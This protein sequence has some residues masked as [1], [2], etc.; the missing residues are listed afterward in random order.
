MATTPTGLD[1]DIF[2]WSLPAGA[3]GG[4]NGLLN[5][6][7]LLQTPTQ[8][9]PLIEAVSASS[10]RMKAP[11][12][13]AP[14]P[15]DNISRV[16]VGLA[17]PGTFTLEFAVQL[18]A[19]PR[20]DS[21]P[22]RYIFIGAA[23]AQGGTGGLLL[24]DAGI[25]VVG[26]PDGASIFLPGSEGLL[27]D[28]DDVLLAEDLTFRLVVQ[29]EKDQ[30]DLYVT[31]ASLL[32]SGHVLRYTLPVPATTLG[33][34]DTALVELRG[35]VGFLED[36]TPED[37]P[38]LQLKS[39][40]LSSKALIPNKRPI[41]SV[42]ADQTVNKAQLVQ[43]SGTGSSDAE[44]VALT[45]AWTI[46]AQPEGSNIKL[47]GAQPAYDEFG[48]AA[49]LYY[50]GQA[51]PGFAVGA[52]IHNGPAGQSEL[53]TASAVVDSSDPVG[54]F[55]YVLSSTA[56]FTVGDVITDDTN[57]VT[58][59]SISY[60]N[61]IKI[62]SKLSGSGGNGQIVKVEKPTI[63]DDASELMMSVE[64]DGSVLITLRFQNGTPVGTTTPQELY[65]AL[66]VSSA[67][68]YN[69]QVALLLSAE[70][71]AGGFGSEGMVGADLVLA[72]GVDS[73]EATPSFYATHVGQY[74]FQLVVSD[75]VL[76][77][78]P[79]TMF[80][81]CLETTTALGYVP[82]ADFVWSY[83][84]DFWAK[85]TDKGKVTSFW[86]GLIQLVGAEMLRL[87]GI[88]YN[89]S[90]RDIPALMPHR[91]YGFS[92]RVLPTTFVV[93]DEDKKDK[94]TF[95]LIKNADGSENTAMHCRPVD[96]PD[97]DLLTQTLVFD[98]A[99]QHEKPGSP[100]PGDFVTVVTG[101]GSLFAQ[102]Q[103]FEKF[104]GEGTK[105]VLVD[106]GNTLTD[107]TVDFHAL[108]VVAGTTITLSGGPAQ[109]NQ[110]TVKSVAKTVLTFTA[111]T[112]LGGAPLVDHGW[113]AG[114][115]IVIEEDVIPSYQVIASGVKSGQSKGS[116]V[117]GNT[118][119]FDLSHGEFDGDVQAG[120][121]LVLD[122]LEWGDTKN[123]VAVKVPAFHE[124]ELETDISAGWKGI[125]W[126]VVRSLAEEAVSVEFSPYL[127]VQEDL[128]G[129]LSPGDL[130]SFGAAGAPPLTGM[131]LSVGE[132]GI[133]IRCPSLTSSYELLE[134]IRVVGVTGPEE[135][136]A[137]PR[138]QTSGSQQ[139]TVLSSPLDYTLADY[140]TRSDEPLRQITFVH[141]KKTD[142]AH[143]VGT[144][145]SSATSDFTG[146]EGQYLFFHFKGE[147]AYG[148]HKIT[149]VLSP[150]SVELETN[151]PEPSTGIE[152]SVLPYHAHKLPPLN[153]WA[154][155]VYVD[156]SETIEN[157]FGL[158]VGL[159][160]DDLEE[161]GVEYLPAVKAVW[162]ALWHG[163]TVSNIRLGVQA[164]FNLP[165]AEE[166]GLII[167]ID[168]DY[169]EDT[170][171]VLVQDT[172]NAQSVRSYYY[173]LG[174]GLAHN[175][176]AH[177]ILGARLLK[178]SQEMDVLQELSI[179]EAEDLARDLLSG[180][181]I[182]NEALIRSHDPN[183]TDRMTAPGYFPYL[184]G[185]EVEAFAPL[186]RGAKVVDYVSDPDWHEPFLPGQNMIKKFHT[187]K[188]EID[189][190]NVPTEGGFDLAVDF[191]RRIKPVHTDFILVGVK[192]VSD[193][194]S[195]TEKPEFRGTYHQVDDSYSS[196]DAA[197]MTG[198]IAVTLGGVNKQFVLPAGF[199]SSD[200]LHVGKLFRTTSGD[201]KGQARRITDYD[202]ATRTVTLDHA[203]LIT[204]TETVGFAISSAPNVSG[205]AH[206]F[207][208]YD[209]QGNWYPALKTISGK[210][211]GTDW[212]Y[213][214]NL[215]PGNQQLAPHGGEPPTAVVD[216]Q[217][218]ALS[219]IF[220]NGE[221]VRLTDASGPVLGTLR[222]HYVIQT[223]ML[224]DITS[225]FLPRS[226][227]TLYGETSG[228]TVDVDSRA[229]GV[230]PTYSALNRARSRIWLPLKPD[231]IKGQDS[232]LGDLTV[233]S[234]SDGPT[235]VGMGGTLSAE[236][237]FYDNWVL[238]VTGKGFSR[239][240]SYS[241]SGPIKSA[242]LLAPIAG[243]V[244]TDPITLH[245][246]RYRTRLA[247][248]SFFDRGSVIVGTNSK[249]VAT[250][251]YAGPS[252][253]LVEN[254]TN[255]PDPYQAFQLGEE[256][257]GAGGER[258]EIVDDA[259]FVYPDV[260]GT[261][262]RQREVGPDPHAE[263][264][265]A[266]EVDVDGEEG[267]LDKGLVLDDVEPFQY[268]VDPV[269][270]PALVPSQHPGLFW[271]LDQKIVYNHKDAAPTG[272]GPEPDWQPVPAVDA[273]ETNGG[274]GWHSQ[275]VQDVFLCRTVSVDGDPVT[276]KVP[277]V[278]EVLLGI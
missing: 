96:D 61:R 8:L 117:D 194:I 64:D 275:V 161:A 101:T 214:D 267:S 29:H 170:G 273:D 92:T 122:G 55:V 261:F 242:T 172:A 228:A 2:D 206:H 186:S 109:Q 221:R 94:Q 247:G 41:A 87:W 108:G 7:D 184:V 9:P 163:P 266:F 4:A 209:G 21:L 139:A 173:P 12:T 132:Q 72:D 192:N 249:A 155:Y 90:L 274:P 65:D 177:Q 265:V 30:A 276:A 244:A 235:L 124:L 15:L 171:R 160:K 66:T 153:W 1:F 234:Y 190:D 99:G 217:V 202:H 168:A 135:V 240:V 205:F 270:P 121:L 253:L 58:I 26:G 250:V 138:L 118:T 203:L 27:Y 32:A 219:G 93:K 100:S 77:S 150:T 230:W 5:S 127:M 130:A 143:G 174:A 13:V 200:D 10:V 53:A 44:G 43:L 167:D 85:V 107:D 98:K 48:T 59:T 196:P 33:L 154:E 264:R 166:A 18:V 151:F 227:V 102:V 263:Y 70:L 115:V 278:D 39:F 180:K 238:E 181:K 241:G 6:P 89:K 106:G 262:D 126:K 137:I 81:T 112:V 144:A 50:T 91:W 103:R 120:D 134:F 34:G 201:D 49:R 212:T 67:A 198:T 37:P 259:Y 128:D 105:G 40:R 207:D 146:T 204:K 176:A 183:L 268:P 211:Y 36:G 23:D 147:Q 245:E 113:Q 257:V 148:H 277:T 140:T 256:V 95:A 62:V 189:L 73:A 210:E 104:L 119:F 84:S 169:S 187:F 193:A 260:I 213:D 75:G 232:G 272:P 38:E 156:N 22:D 114:G 231:T 47:S 35:P 220:R 145:F 251:L 97:G 76:N 83:L 57:S 129:K 179:E 46:L 142:G 188:V 51:D 123:A 237:G 24:S 28:E 258:A 71:P 222:A 239:I 175:P 3:I 215:A 208:H 60:G 178:A 14:E 52:T 125:S 233:L 133:G 17:V 197:Y 149:K 182:A 31:P 164:F 20:A 224:L 68:G 80:V 157:N 136:R 111:P 246:P 271:W 185:D 248:A 45:Y 110:F 74:K 19:L 223:R 226:G 11:G 116:D 191:V 86:S 216:Y 141:D 199:P 162:F 152:F 42:S 79:T 158:L 255:A 159:R 88:D 16:S 269:H 229:L 236:D 25:A 225:G 82:D 195:V 165:F 218:G 54:D 131:V 56:E 69:T 78:L 243:V 252:Y 63:A 254:V